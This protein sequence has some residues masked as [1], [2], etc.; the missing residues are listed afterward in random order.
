VASRLGKYT[1]ADK[2]STPPKPSSADLSS[3]PT[4][5]PSRFRRRPTATSPCASPRLL[6]V[7]WP[8]EPEKEAW[9]A[10]RRA[11]TRQHWWLTPTSSAPSASLR[12]A[13][14]GA[15][16]TGLIIGSGQGLPKAGPVGML[17]GYSIMGLVC[18]G[19]SRAIAGLLPLLARLGD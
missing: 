11:L 17:L 5:S 7:S 18:F 1:L 8:V 16:G 12:I 9:A 4:A 19:V 6:E 10:G 2:V 15:V 13:I 3:L 14:G